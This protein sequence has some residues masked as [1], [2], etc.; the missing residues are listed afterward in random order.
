LLIPANG[1]SSSGKVEACTIDASLIDAP[2]ID[3]QID[4]FDAYGSTV[5]ASATFITS[6]ISPT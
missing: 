1:V 3:A 5:F 6:V 4:V 2:L